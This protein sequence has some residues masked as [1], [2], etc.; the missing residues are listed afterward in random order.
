MFYIKNQILNISNKCLSFHLTILYILKKEEL[1]EKK[2]QN[3]KNIKR[4]QNNILLFT[5]PA[6]FLHDLIHIISLS[7]EIVKNN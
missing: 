6:K 5:I 2:I 7:E 3:E 1:I 4:G